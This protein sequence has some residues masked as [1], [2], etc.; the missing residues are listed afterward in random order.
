M[1][2]SLQ[3]SVFSVTS[4]DSVLPFLPWLGGALAVVLAAW[5]V[6]RMIDRRQQAEMEDGLPGVLIPPSEPDP[7]D[8]ILETAQRP[9]GARA[10]PIVIG[11]AIVAVGALAVLAYRNLPRDTDWSPDYVSTTSEAPAVTPRPE[12][13]Q[14]EDPDEVAALD[15]GSGERL[16]LWSG[17]G[18]TGRAGALLPR[19]LAVVLLDSAGRPMADREIRFEVAPGGGTVERDSVRTSD[20]GLAAT[21]WRLG[22]D[23]GALVVRAYVPNR[24]ELSLRIP[25]TL[26]PT[27]PAVATSPSATPPDS[28]TGVSDDAGGTG[29]DT[30]PTSGVEGPLIAPPARAGTWATGGVHTCRVNGAGAITC[31]GSGGSDGSHALG[32]VIWGVAAG[33]FHVCGVT[34]SS[35]AGCWSVGGGD[36]QAI[37]GERS[38]QGTRPVELAI[39]SEHACARTSNG[40]VFCWGRNS[41]GQLGTPGGDRTQPTQVE[42]LSDVTR[43]V[44]GWNHSCALTRSGQAFCWGA[45]DAGQ[46]GV[47]DTDDRARPA[48][49][50]QPAPWTTLA[51]GSA[52]TCGL[53][54]AG[55]AWCWGDNQYGQI[56]ST[57]VVRAIRPGRV[58]TDLSFR[59]LVSGGVH[60][61]GLTGAGNGWCWGR[62]LFGQLGDGTTR[63]SSSPVPVSGG[64]S[65]ARLGGGGAHTCGETVNGSLYCWG[66]NI[67]GQLADGTRENRT[68]P[69]PVERVR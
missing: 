3:L 40:R 49:V 61:C 55:Q 37:A 19:S 46:L 4:V 44:S 21:S 8:E 29:R 69:I 47:G 7:E 12:T 25:A 53:T 10:R 15:A 28:D 66:N 27:A 26:D 42:G 6:V 52:H 24:P 62:N 39:G 13:P 64:L 45:N 58:A 54:Q 50:L 2:F 41:R 23:P 34:E 32:D 65:F 1:C 35:T 43:I 17:G 22:R 14:P 59:S 60:T 33:V 56:G 67:Q 9:S 20:S 31:W 36:R 16:V 48:A 11:L 18:Q 5:L 57:E 30:T 68:T 51:S 38:F 63:D